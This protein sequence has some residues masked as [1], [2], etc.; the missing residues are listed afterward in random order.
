MYL[1]PY[2]SLTLFLTVCNCPIG[3][4][5]NFPNRK[6]LVLDV[7]GVLADIVRFEEAVPP[8]FKEDRTISN[9]KGYHSCFNFFF[10]SI[11]FKFCG[12]S[13]TCIFPVFKRPHCDSFLDFC[14]QH[15]N[16][17]LWSS[18]TKWALLFYACTSCG[19]VFF[20]TLVYKAPFI[21]FRNNLDPVVDYIFGHRKE[22]LL[23]CWVSTIP[24]FVHVKTMFINI[25]CG[26]IGK[27]A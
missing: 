22:K 8:E 11:P 7:N 23:F 5:G 6:L 17:G 9:K 26:K 27:E 24:I 21:F 12:T 14:F 3:G 18:R 19:S 4:D 25:G 1:C 15:Y 13:F 2:V 20:G 16:V 10:T